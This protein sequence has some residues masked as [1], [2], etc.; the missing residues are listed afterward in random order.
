MKRERVKAKGVVE[1]LK[2]PFGGRT[3]VQ[4]IRRQIH[5]SFKASNSIHLLWRLSDCRVID[6]FESNINHHATS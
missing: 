2:A 3:S 4:R 5:A 6:F 1:E